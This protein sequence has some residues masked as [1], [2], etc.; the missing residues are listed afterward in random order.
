MLLS[1]RLQQGGQ[2]ALRGRPCLRVNGV[3]PV[4]LRAPDDLPDLRR[5]DDVGRRA[6]GAPGVEDH[7]VFPPPNL[8]LLCA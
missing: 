3:V 1:V 8:L 5:R 7:S 6:V 4:A 2:Q